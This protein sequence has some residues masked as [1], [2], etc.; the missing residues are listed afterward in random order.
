[1]LGKWTRWKECIVLLPDQSVED[2]GAMEY[3]FQTS[4]LRKKRAQMHSYLYPQFLITIATCFSCVVWC[5][6][7]WNCF[8]VVVLPFSGFVLSQSRNM[9]RVS[10]SCRTFSLWNLQ[11]TSSYW[12]RK[13]VRKKLWVVPCWFSVC[14]EGLSLSSLT[15]SQGVSS[16]QSSKSKTSDQPKGHAT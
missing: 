8:S 15:G 16:I 13:S 1:M 11:G 5:I 14:Q 9:H 2:K 10:L 6:K 12:E 3:P 7:E 4:Y